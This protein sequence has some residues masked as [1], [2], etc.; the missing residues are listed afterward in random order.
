MGFIL[1]DILKRINNNDDLNNS[2]EELEKSYKQL[3]ENVIFSQQLAN[4]GSWTYDMHKNEV[5]WTEEIYKIL[6]RS[7][8]EFNGDFED[9]LLYVHPDDLEE[10]K[11]ATEDAIR[12]R[13]YDIE[14]RIITP[15]GDER[16]VHE[17][18]KVLYDDC[19]NPAKMVG[20]IQDITRLKTDEPTN[21]YG[22]TQDITEIKELQRAI[23]LKQEEIYRIKNQFQVLVQESTDVF[24]IIAADGTIKYISNTIEKVLGCKPEERIGKKVFEFYEG[25]ELQKLTKMVESVLNVPAKIVK[26]DIVLKTESG[27]EIFLEVNMKNLLSEPYVQGI[28]LNFRDITER[29]KMQKRIEHIATHDE[30]TGLPNQ[31]SLNKDLEAQWCCAK[32]S[33]TTFALMMLDINGF[34]Y[35]NDALG[36]QTGDQ[37]IIE[38]SKRLKD[39]LGRD[40]NIYRYSGDQFAIITKSLSTLQEYIKVAEDIISLFS[41]TFKVGSYELNVTISIGI[42]I[43]YKDTQASGLLIKYANTALFRAKNEGK[44]QY[45]IYSSD[46]NIQSYKQFNLRNDLCKS[47]ER[48]QL[49]VYYQPQV[50]LKNGKILAVEALVR[51]EHPDWGIVSPD[52]FI[53]LAEET[54]FIIDIGNWVLREVCRS[55]RQWLDNGLPCIKVSVNYSSVQFYQ[56]NFVENIINTIDEFKLD[57]HFLIMEITESILTDKNSKA[58]DYIQKLQSFGVQI[59]LDDFGTGFSSL[60][61]LNNYDIH[62]LKIGDSFIKNIPKELNQVQIK[63]RN[64]ILFADGSFTTASPALFFK[65]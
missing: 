46:I 16:Y 20:I 47:I 13:E 28:V 21:T 56:N 12:G 1:K 64:D 58:A 41:Q 29:V 34:K 6:G 9:F 30:L 7:R 33:Y 3:K 65:R 49:E 63:M 39:F 60:A 37:L 23:E 54:G 10:V 35:I 44:N 11:K 24:E 26:E 51:W 4:I 22:M 36:Y 62:I 27:K 17:K 32:G 61:Y 45:K 53:Y 8:Q 15:E 18:T 5:F 40:Y 25:E 42:S 50:N 55:Y 38:I 14:Y 52:E 59:A 48:G 31:I 2:K 43:C 57:P 19:N